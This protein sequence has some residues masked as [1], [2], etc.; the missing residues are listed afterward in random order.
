MIKSDEISKSILNT[1][2][3]DNKIS[4]AYLFQTNDSSDNNELIFSFVKNIICPYKKNKVCKT[5]NIC[6]R[7][8]D[9]NYTELKIINPDGMYIKRKGKMKLKLII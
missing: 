9:G 4:H 2:I 8:D 5:C 7:I 3:N 6:K 1:A